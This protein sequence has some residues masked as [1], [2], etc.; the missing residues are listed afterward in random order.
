MKTITYELDNSDGHLSRH[1][2]VNQLRNDVHTKGNEKN[3]EIK[4]YKKLSYDK[5]TINEKAVHTPVNT[6]YFW[7]II[8]ELGKPD[9][10]EI[11]K[12]LIKYQTFDEAA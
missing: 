6:A 4:V 7:K 1:D 11:V 9:G 8:D 5:R 2:I 12:V 3:F 10:S